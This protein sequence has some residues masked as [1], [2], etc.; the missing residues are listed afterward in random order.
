[1]QLTHGVHRD[2]EGQYIVE[3]SPH[4]ECPMRFFFQNG[5]QL[6]HISKETPAFWRSNKL[7]LQ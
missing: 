4:R 3:L 6:C 2:N 1:M 7:F 5:L